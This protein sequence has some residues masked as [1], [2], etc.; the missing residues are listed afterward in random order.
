[1]TTKENHANMTEDAL[2]VF[3]Q[4]FMKGPTAVADLVNPMG[5]GELLKS[6]LAFY[7]R[8]WLM[9]SEHG[10]EFAIAHE[11]DKGKALVNGQADAIDAA[12]D[13][14]IDTLQ[15]SLAAMVRQA[16]GIITLP[17]SEIGAP[18]VCTVYPEGETVVFC[19]AETAA[20]PA[21]AA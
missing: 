2:A 21:E 16:G 5:R 1:M 15:R 8:G 14:T 20:E 18:G 17:M 6:R 7:C 9:L 3:V 12:R 19:L 13:I 11:L 10:L 4:L